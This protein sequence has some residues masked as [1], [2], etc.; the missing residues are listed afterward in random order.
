MEGNQLFDVLETTRDLASFQ[1]AKET[2]YSE[3]SDMIV[4]N[5]EET[6]STY[7]GLQESDTF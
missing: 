4:V 2:R 1:D 3:D 7:D 6:L 5:E